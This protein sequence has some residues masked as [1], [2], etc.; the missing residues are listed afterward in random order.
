MFKS[1]NLS[2]LIDNNQTNVSKSTSSFSNADS[3]SRRA[4][5]LKLCVKS[6]ERETNELDM[7][8]NE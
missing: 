1:V 5:K 4:E 3:S 6:V 8:K 7:I 2:K